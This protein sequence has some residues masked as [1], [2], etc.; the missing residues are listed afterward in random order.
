MFPIYELYVVMVVQELF[1]VKTTLSTLLRLDFL[2]YLLSFY[3][4]FHC[5]NNVVKLQRPLFVKH[6]HYIRKFEVALSL[7]AGTHMQI[8]QSKL[9]DFE[10]DRLQLR[11]RMVIRIYYTLIG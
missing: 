9:L 8:D 5:Y 6:L 1:R 10:H 4:C 7:V 2:R 3:L 11:E